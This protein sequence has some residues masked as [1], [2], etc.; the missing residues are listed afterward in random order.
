[1]PVDG[2]IIEGQSNVDESMITG[3]PMPVKQT[4]GDNV[5]GGTVNQTGSFLMRAER[6]GRNA[7]GADRPNG[8]A[9]ATQPR[10]HSETGRH[11]LRLFRSSSDQ[12]RGHY[13]Y[14][15]VD[16]SGPRR[17]SAYALVNAVSVLI[18]ACPCALG[19]A[20]PMSDHGRRRARAQA[21]DFG[22]KR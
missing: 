12:H 17:A 10:A 2:V 15:V 11:S 6:I 1:M 18:I 7:A 5:I 19:L 13:F 16:L 20:T 8:R 22:K 21:G 14:R 3:E 4:T 9:S